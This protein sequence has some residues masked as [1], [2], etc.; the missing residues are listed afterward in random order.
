MRTTATSSSWLAI[1]V[2]ALLGSCTSQTTRE[3][4]LESYTDSIG[5]R[6]VPEAQAALA[7]RVG[8]TRSIEPNG[9]TRLSEWRTRTKISHWSF[10]PIGDPLYPTVIVVTRDVKSGS[11]SCKIRCEAPLQQCDHFVQERRREVQQTLDE[12]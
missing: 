2:A 1:S 5:Y 6:T 4:P 10:A 3:L 12:I 11:Y 9:W 7:S 8:V